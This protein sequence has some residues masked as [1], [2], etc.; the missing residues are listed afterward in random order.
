[1]GDAGIAIMESFDAEIYNNVVE[2]VKYGLRISLGGG[3]N[4]IHDN[5]FDDCWQCE[6]SRRLT[7]PSLQPTMIHARHALPGV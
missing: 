5:K 7:A 3:N 1:M 2:D 6:C 4:Y